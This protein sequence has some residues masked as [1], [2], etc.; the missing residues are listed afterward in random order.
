[1]GVSVLSRVAS[2]LTTTRV[3]DV[4]SPFRAF[5]AEAVERLHLLQPPFPASEPLLEAVRQALRRYEAREGG[6]EA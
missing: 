6:G 5:R 2:V 3:T 4:S 1:M